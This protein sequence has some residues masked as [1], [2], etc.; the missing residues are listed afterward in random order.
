MTIF[1][2]G[3]TQKSAREFFEAL[4]TAGVRRLIDVR[5]NNVSQLAGFSKRADLEYFLQTI[6]SIPYAH[7]VELAPTQGMLDE[8]KKS[9]GSWEAYEGR[10]LRLMEDRRIEETL[11]REFV[12]GSCLL[13]SEAKPKQC[14]RRLVAE[15]LRSKWG[16][17]T[18]THL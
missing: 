8:Y 13:C 9:G 6:S 15:Y 10:F 16:D 18:I 14:H 11:P 7:R 5:L 3:F 12:D 2:I 1:T 4:R 17:L